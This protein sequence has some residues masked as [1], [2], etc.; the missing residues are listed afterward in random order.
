MPDIEHFRNT[1]T[2][3]VW[4][5]NVGEPDHARMVAN[6]GEFERFTPEPVEPPKPKR[7]AK[8]TRKSAEPEPV[9]DTLD[10]HPGGLDEFAPRAEG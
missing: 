7:R 10:N 4:S 6:P 1:R 5:A 9:A 8:T 3:V 2:G